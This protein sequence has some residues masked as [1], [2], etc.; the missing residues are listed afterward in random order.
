MR[1]AVR[2]LSGDREL[3]SEMVE[4]K[5]SSSVHILDPHT[6]HTI[7]SIRDPLYLRLYNCFYY[8]HWLSDR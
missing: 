7:V 1:I 6:E 2:R 5:D 4:A 8:D 3:A